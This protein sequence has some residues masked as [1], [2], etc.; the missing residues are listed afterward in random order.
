METNSS[1]SKSNLSYRTNRP[2]RLGKSYTLKS[3]VW[4][5]RTAP[6]TGTKCSTT[7]AHGKY[8]SFKGQNIL[9][10]QGHP[11]PLRRTPFY[12]GS[13]YLHSK[14]SLLESYTSVRWLNQPWWAL[15]SPLCTAPC[16]WQD[17]LS[18]WEHQEQDCRTLSPEK[19]ATGS[20]KT[21][22]F[23]FYIVNM[24]SRS[25]SRASFRDLLTADTWNIL[26]ESG[27]RMNTDERQEY[28]LLPVSILNF[29]WV[30][31]VFLETQRMEWLVSANGL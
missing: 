2:G 4:G 14:Y 20:W 17:C 19:K 31:R 24:S 5:P 13:T 25:T 15:G 16:H 21:E 3:T 30:A 8:V 22:L 9:I 27:L 26:L 18:K 11:I 6:P 10:L 1:C 12:R 7:W 23:P 29:D 28:R